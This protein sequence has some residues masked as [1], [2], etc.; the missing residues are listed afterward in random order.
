MVKSSLEEKT[1]IDIGGGLKE[2]IGWKRVSGGE[3]SYVEKAG[4]RAKKS[5]AA[6]RSEGIYRKC[7]SPG[8]GEGPRK[9]MRKTLAETSRNEGYG[10]WSGQFLQRRGKDTNPSTKLPPKM[11]HA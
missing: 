9:S 1:K 3:R 2:K 5:A 6:S 10:S 11:C 8:M 7:R 4:K